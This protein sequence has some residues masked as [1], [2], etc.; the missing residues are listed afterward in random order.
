ME[1]NVL[2]AQL[3]EQLDALLSNEHNQVANLAN[4][5][6]LLFMNIEDI[7][8]AGFYVYKDGELILGPFQGKIACMHIPIG[9]GVCGTCFATQTIQR[10]AN[11]H[12]FE[13]HIACDAQSNSEIVLPIYKDG[14]VF[15]VLDIDSQLHNRFDEEDEKG[16]RSFV[17]VLEQHI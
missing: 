9:K 15:A 11:V 4:A 2:Y 10:I 13:G 1:K 3:C 5:S 16:L 6:A 12:E 17:T 8:W 7:N 14:E